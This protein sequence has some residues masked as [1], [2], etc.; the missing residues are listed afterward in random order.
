MGNSFRQVN[1]DV[2]WEGCPQVATSPIEIKVLLF[3]LL[4]PMH[5]Q[6]SQMAGVNGD[7]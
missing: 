2:F 5:K 6:P 1:K 3:Y 7:G 4:F